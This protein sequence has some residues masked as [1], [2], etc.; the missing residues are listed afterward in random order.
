MVTA[1]ICRSGLFWSVTIAHTVPWAKPVAVALKY[2]CLLPSVTPSLMVVM[3]TSINASPA[4]IVTVAGN[5]ASLVLDEERP[6]I[7]AEA[8]AVLRVT[9]SSPALVKPSAKV[10]GEGV[11]DSVGPSLSFTIKLADT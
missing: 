4:G 10:N 1:G 8:V 2:T 11:N 6:T 9:R 3:G 7:S 5:K